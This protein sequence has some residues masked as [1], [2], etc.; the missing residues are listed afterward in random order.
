MIVIVDTHV[1]ETAVQT[2]I[3]YIEIVKQK[4][5]AHQNLKQKKLLYKLLYQ[6]QAKHHNL[7]TLEHVLKNG[8]NTSLFLELI[9]DLDITEPLE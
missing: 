7:E 3:V 9:C 5:K 1:K 2:F 8:K 6:N 4:H